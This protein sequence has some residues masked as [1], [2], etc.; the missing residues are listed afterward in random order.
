MHFAAEHNAVEV[1][2]LLLEKDADVE[3]KA[4][5]DATLLHYAARYDSVQ[6]AKLL[7][8][9]DVDVE[10]KDNDGKTPLYRA[11]RYSVQVAKLLRSQKHQAQSLF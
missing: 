9:K 4:N 2:K 11:E 1:A 7:L 8:E 3:A 10:A 6:V 5:N